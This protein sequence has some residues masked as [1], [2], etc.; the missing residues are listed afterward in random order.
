[1]CCCQ[2]VGTQRVPPPEGGCNLTRGWWEVRTNVFVRDL[3]QFD[4]RR[5]QGRGGRTARLRRSAAHDGCV[6]HKWRPL[7]GRQTPAYPELVGDGGRVRQVVL[8]GEV[9]GS[10][11]DETAQFLRDLV[12][13]KED[14]STGC[15][16]TVREVLGDSRHFAR[17]MLMGLRPSWLLAC[18]CL[19]SRVKSTTTIDENRPCPQNPKPRNRGTLN[20]SP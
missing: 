10:F 12:S 14:G 13:A 19:F 2:E 7:R 17:G 8:T 11:L 9:G 15:S 5:L 6:P 4:T 20:P 3:D 16:H 18:D 1:M